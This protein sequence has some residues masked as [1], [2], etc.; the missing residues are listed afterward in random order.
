MLQ[1]IYSLY[2]IT[3]LINW[4]FWKEFAAEDLYN[5]DFSHNYS[6]DLYYLTY[7]S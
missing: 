5:H 4:I 3:T 1:M 6:K 7:F 2:T